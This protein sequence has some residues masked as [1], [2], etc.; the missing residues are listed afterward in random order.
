L[1]LAA[2]LAGCAAPSLAAGVDAGSVHHDNS[3]RS[4]VGSLMQATT[5]AHAPTQRPTRAPSR[6]DSSSAAVLESGKVNTQAP[7]L[8]LAPLSGGSGGGKAQHTEPR[9]GAYLGCYDGAAMQL[10]FGR[11]TVALKQ[12]G[13]GK[14][15]DHCRALKM[16]VLA[17]SRALQCTCLAAVPDPAAQLPLGACE[18]LAAGGAAAAG[19]AGAATAVPL[20]YVHG[21]PGQSCAAQRMELSARRL[22]AA[23]NAHNAVFDGTGDGLTM[24][25]RGSDGVRVA[26]RQAQLYGM[27]SFQA[28]TSD[29]PGVI[30]GAYVRTPAL[31]PLAGWHY[32]GMSTK[33][34]WSDLSSDY[35]LLHND[36]KAGEQRDSDTASTRPQA[37]RLSP[38]SPPPTAALGQT[39]CL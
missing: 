16:P 11:A 17:I 27:L 20:F 25:M 12:G 29:L 3:N 5:K 1:L 33:L 2:L 31:S 30:T 32:G 7:P 36:G 10:S 34:T 15:V 35:A 39:R 24:W 6:G 21:A 19:A 22:E 8:G 37:Q 28:R 18:S 14:C 26:A 23:Y 9:H 38:C 13:Y 4:G